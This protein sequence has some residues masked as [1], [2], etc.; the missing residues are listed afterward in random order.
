VHL[1]PARYGRKPMAFVSLY[2]I[3][4]S[5]QNSSNNSPK[6]NLWPNPTNDLLWI[7][8]A[9]AFSNISVQ[10][11]NADGRLVQQSNFT[12]ASKEML[13]DVSKISSGIYFITVTTEAGNT[14]EK[15]VKY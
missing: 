5:I 9:S 14:T 4:T 15:F 13:L 2:D 7:N 1:R 3:E 12:H 8:C 6:F 11:T 10:I